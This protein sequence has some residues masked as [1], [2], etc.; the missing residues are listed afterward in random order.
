[1][2]R[3]ISLKVAVLA[4][5]LVAFLQAPVLAKDQSPLDI[6]R[7]QITT[8]FARTDS[9]QSQI[10]NIQLTPGPQGPQGNP[11]TPGTQGPK[12]DTG[13][14]LDASKMYKV[15]ATAS[16]NPG[17]LINTQASCRD[18]NDIAINGGF[19]LGNENMAVMSSELNSGNPG[20][21]PAGWIAS[22]ANRGSAPSFFVVNTV[23]VAI[24]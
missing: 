24:D 3:N 5:I 8:L 6:I 19:V 17:V 22:A 23:C 12:G 7:E 16:V 21:D 13:L 18:N 15:F 20:V 10:T 11:G 2:K 1:M 4:I 9:L 14:G